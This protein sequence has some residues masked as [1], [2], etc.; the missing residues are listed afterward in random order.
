MLDIYFGVK[1][2][3]L[4]EGNILALG[5]IA[6]FSSECLYHVT[7][8]PAPY[9]LVHEVTKVGIV[10]LVNFSHPGGCMVVFIFS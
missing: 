7:L 2:L 10:N 4:E 8:P 3:D 5:Y 9:E 1:L 6:N